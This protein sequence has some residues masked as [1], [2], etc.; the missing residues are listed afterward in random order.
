[1][2]YTFDISSSFYAINL[3]NENVSLWAL[4][5]NANRKNLIN[6]IG[7]CSI[8]DKTFFTFSGYN[9]QTNAMWLVLY[10]SEGN[11]YYTQTGVLEYHNGVDVDGYIVTLPV[12]LTQ[13][14]KAS[15][16]ICAD[17]KLESA[18]QSTPNSVEAGA[19]YKIDGVDYISLNSLLLKV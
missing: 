16:V 19:V 13:G 5:K 18:L 3:T 8:N 9:E 14:S 11:I 6:C 2:E 10:D 7:K 15:G 12:Y 1:M 17:Y 4:N